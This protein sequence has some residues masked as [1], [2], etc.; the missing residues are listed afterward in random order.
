MYVHRPVINIVGIHI[1]HG[2]VQQIPDAIQPHSAEAA[3]LIAMVIL[4]AWGMMFLQ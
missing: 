1:L 3:L 4:T 2:I